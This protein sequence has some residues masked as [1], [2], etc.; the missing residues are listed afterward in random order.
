MSA[1]LSTPSRRPPCQ[2]AGLGD[3][4]S[5]PPTSGPTRNQGCWEDEAS[6]SLSH[7]YVTAAGCHGQPT[8]AAGPIIEF[9]QLSD[10]INRTTGVYS[11]Q[12]KEIIAE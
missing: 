5:D 1:S 8:P 3:S 2:Q 11:G 4:E 12:R 6:E 10:F 9:A 7:S